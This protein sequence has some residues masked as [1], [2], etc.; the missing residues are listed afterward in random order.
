MDRGLH[1][2]FSTDLLQVGLCHWD[3][4][5]DPGD[6]RTIRTMSKRNS[7]GNAIPMKSNSSKS[8]LP[9]LSLS[10]SSTSSSRWLTSDVSIYVTDLI[11][12]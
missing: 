5:F 2:T 7:T 6:C 12:L 11:G 9:F 3:A 8:I 10:A 1:D 4:L